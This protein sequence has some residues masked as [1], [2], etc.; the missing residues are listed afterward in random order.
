MLTDSQKKF[1]YQNYLKIPLKD[2]V[3]FLGVNASTVNSFIGLH[4]VAEMLDN[5][6]ELKKEGFEPIKVSKF[7]KLQIEKTKRK[8]EIVIIQSKLN[9]EKGNDISEK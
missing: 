5:F 2:I 3:E 1:I 9:N 7:E 8:K 6:E 4:T